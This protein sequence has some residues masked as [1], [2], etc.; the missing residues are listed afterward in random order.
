MKISEKKDNKP[1]GKWI[2]TLLILGLLGIFVFAFKGKIK[3]TKEKLAKKEAGNNLGATFEGST[4][5]IAVSSDAYR[6]LSAKRDE[7]IK[8]GLLFTSK[9]DMVD[10]DIKIDGKEYACKLRLKGDLLDHLSGERWSFRIVLKG[11]E[12]W[13]GMKTFSIHNSKARSHTAEWLMHQLFKKE[14]ILVPDYDFIKVQLNGKD[15]GVYAYEHHFENQMLEKNGRD[16]GPILKHNDDAY[17]ENVHKK[18]KPFPWIEASQIEL[19]NKEHIKDPAFKQSFELAHGMLNA[20]VQEEKTASEVFDLELMAKYFAMLDLSHAWHAAQFTNIRFYLNNFTGKLEPVAFDCFGDHLPN[21]TADW[22]A[23]GESFNSRTSK[24]TAYARSD[25]Y[26]YLMFQDVTFFEAYMK[27]LDKF[28]DPNYLNKFKNEYSENLASRVKFINSD[29]AY[30]DYESN[31]ETI[32]GKAFYTRKKLDAK[33]DMSLKAYRIN[34]APENVSMESY[35]YFPLEVLGFGDENEM[36]SKLSESIIIEAYNSLVPIKRFEYAHNQEIEFIYFRTLGLKNI[37]KVRVNKFS[38]PQ[39]NVK[40]DQFNLDDFVSLPFV[41][42]VG[43]ELEIAAGNHVINFPVIIPSGKVLRISAGTQ[44]EFAKNGGIY[45]KSPIVALGSKS[46]PIKVFS[47]GN[48]GSG[49]LVADS[50]VKSVFSHCFFEGLSDYK[51][52]NVSAKG[53]INIYRSEAEFNTCQFLN[54]ESAEALSMWYSEV[55]LEQCLFKDC[56]GTAIKSMYSSSDII[57]CDFISIGKNGIS[58]EKGSTKFA[59]SN[60]K[61]VLNRA[62]DFG[63]NAKVFGKNNSVIDSYQSLFVS[64]Q[65][66]VKLIK[67]YNENITRG[68]EVRGQEKTPPKVDIEQ[69]NFKKVETLYLIEQGFYI[70]VNGKRELG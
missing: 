12:E 55:R 1:F 58:A 56:I 48:S 29:K 19:F 7:A 9:D 57:A 47:N 33:P 6:K 64:N 5:S 16:T 18:L 3:E 17:W 50:K 35:H 70:M 8:R 43:N 61:E 67:F 25:V 52:Q 38:V 20:F 4:F 53:A 60:F 36:T 40:T 69:F 34:N 45:T 65:S 26:S 27:Y 15:L 62:L 54:I 68:L 14:G 49:I 44:I 32:F 11:N 41:N 28:T 21:V 63:E 46:N 22:T 13:N 39:E 31:W 66:D 59:E 2:P 42:Q 10:A 30:K 37:H 23:Y 51:S 24:A